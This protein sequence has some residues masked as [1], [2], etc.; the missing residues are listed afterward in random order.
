MNESMRRILAELLDY[1][2]TDKMD[3]AMTSIQGVLYLGGQ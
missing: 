1:D 2:E 3:D